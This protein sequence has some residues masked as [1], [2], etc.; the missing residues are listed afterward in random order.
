MIKISVSASRKYDVIMEQGAISK[1]DAL[2]ENAG[3]SSGKKLCIVTDETVNE[4]YAG[5]D[6]SLI[7]I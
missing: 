7:H 2:L 1:I 6:L 4:L 3:I 5:E